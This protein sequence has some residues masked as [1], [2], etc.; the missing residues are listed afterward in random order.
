[1]QNLDEIKEIFRTEFGV[2]AD[3]FTIFEFSLNDAKISKEPDVNLPGVYVH[4]SPT[5]GVIKVGKAHDN[6]RRRAM[7]HIRKNTH[8]KGK[9]YEMALLADGPEAKVFL[10]NLVSKEDIHWLLSLEY[11]L[12]SKLRPLIRS[13][14]RG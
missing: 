2:L 1:M 13:E 14:R 7:T 6:S 5:L 11:F 12:E 3:R 10:F 9:S 4:W 8:N